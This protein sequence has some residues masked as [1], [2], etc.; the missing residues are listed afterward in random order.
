[1][2]TWSGSAAL[3]ATGLAVLAGCGGGGGEPLTA[4]QLVA[5]GDEICKQGQQRFAE[6]QSQPPANASDAVDQTEQLIDSANEELDG[7][8]DLN[9]PDELSDTYSQYLDAKQ[10]ALDLL[11]DGRDA[12]DDQ[13]AK[14]YGELQS[15]VA[16]AGPER[17]KLAREVGFKIC[18]RPQPNPGA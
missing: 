9:P 3:A 16:A 13:N 15:K 8:R 1:M 10:E 6:I 11:E 5:Q 17:L 18:S 4:Q 7:L 14:L 12:A 2:R